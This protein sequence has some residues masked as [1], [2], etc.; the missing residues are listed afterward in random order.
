MTPPNL[1]EPDF[2]NIPVEMKN[3]ARWLVWDLEPGKDGKE[4]KVPRCAKTGQK[5]YVTNPEDWCSFEEA[6]RAYQEHGY[7]GIG[8]ALGDGF[9]GVDLD[10]CVDSTTGEWTWGDASPG[11]ELNPVTIVKDIDGYAEYSPSLTGLHII[12]KGQLP[13]G[14]CQRT[15][16]KNPK[17]KIEVFKGKRF[18]TVTGRKVAGNCALPDVTD[19]LHKLHRMVF[20]EQEAPRPVESKCT[21]TCSLSNDELIDLACREKPNF[22]SLYEGDTSGG[23]VAPRNG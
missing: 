6:V 7:T 14:G 13:L 15:L 20:P 16:S 1:P 19:K 22:R 18:F 17:R 4:T 12:A 23:S 2:H 10:G 8:F 5:A 3:Q 9:A 21:G 11:P